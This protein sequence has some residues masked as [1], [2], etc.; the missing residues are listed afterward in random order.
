MVKITGGQRIDLLGVRREQLPEIWKELGMRSGHAYSKAFRTVKTCVGSEFCRFGLG[1]STALGVALEERF[2]GLESPGKLKLAVAGC[3]RNCSEAL[4]KDVGVVA[5]EGGRWEVYVG[6]AA[7]AHVRKGDLLC[8]LDTPEQVLT[9][10]GR[11]L[12]YYRENAKY[13]E[14]TYGFVP[15]L[16][17]DAIREVVVEDSGGDGARLD[18]AL[19]AAIEAYQDPWRE[20]EEP[21]H[22][23]QFAAV[24]NGEEAV[25]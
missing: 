16:G 22:P 25:S 18:A 14:R 19:E 1:D 4:V 6:G 3:P 24:L 23:A 21:V 7:G 13:M 5:V 17:I 10:V 8:V 20:A 15:R 9:V 12:Q 11:F 2:K